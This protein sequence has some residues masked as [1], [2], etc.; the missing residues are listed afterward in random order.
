MS[1]V[2]HTYRRADPT[3]RNGIIHQTQRYLDTLGRW[4]T[5]RDLG[6]AEEI[7]ER[8]AQVTGAFFGLKGLVEGHPRLAGLLGIII[9]LHALEQLTGGLAT[10]GMRLY[11]RGRPVASYRGIMIR[12]SPFTPRTAAAMNRLT[13]GRVLAATGYYFFEGGRTWHCQST[14]LQFGDEAR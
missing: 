2:N 10:T 13:G 9:G 4:S 7:P 14:T 3:R 5:Y 1:Y 11:G 8:I 12:K 6:R